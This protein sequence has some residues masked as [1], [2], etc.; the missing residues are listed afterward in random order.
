MDIAQGIEYVGVDDHEVD[1][2][3]GQFAVPN[4]M[5]YNSYV[6][7]D[8]QVAVMD[9][10]DANF[11]DE[12]LSNVERVLAGKKPSYLVVSHMEPDHSAGIFAFMEKFPEC[13]V[14]ATAAAFKM[15]TLFF[16]TDFGDRKVLAKEGAELALGKRTLKFVLAPFVHW[17]EVMMTY[18]AADKILFSADAFGK[19]GANDVDEPWDDEARRYYIGIVGKYG[20]KVQA[21]FKKLGSLEIE[22]ICAL[23]GPV[24]SGDLGHYLGLY[25][26]WSSYA[27]ETKGVFI[28][29]ASAYGNTKRAA[30]FLAAKLGDLG[31]PCELAD[32]ARAD[33]AA[34]IA[35]AFRYEKLVLASV[36]YNAEIFPPMRTFIS[37]LVERNFKN[38]KVALIENGSWAPTAAKVMKA[39][40]EKSEGL[41]YAETQVT[42]RAALND[43]A[44]A[45]LDLLAKELAL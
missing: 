28:A 12:W 22:K 37:G 33:M 15:M 7:L 24:L 35:N 16:G 45:K 36:T 8:E 18:D 41:T 26:T 30:S 42:V 17:P 29:Y 40:L 38:R 20:D 44:C 2:F 5:A 21:L 32:L 31:V 3:E 6:I 19:F 14:V 39:L 27:P 23:H 11:V 43:E 10:V 4:G 13:K 25:A 34:S 1:L 9:S